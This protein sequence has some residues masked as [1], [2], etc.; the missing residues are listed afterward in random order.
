MAHDRL[1]LFQGRRVGSSIPIFLLFGLG[2]LAFFQPTHIPMAA[3]GVG[4]Q[5]QLNPADI[6]W[7]LTASGLV[8]L[9]TPGLAF[10]YGGMVGKKNI[11]SI[12]LQSFVCLGLLSLLWVVVG[13][14]LAFGD[15]Y[16]SLIG[17]PRTYFMFTNVG[18]MAQPSLAAGIPLLLFAMFQLKFAVITPALIT[19]SFAERIRFSSY[20]IFFCFFTL[21]VYCPLAHW[22]WHPQ[23]FLRQ[24]GVLGFAGGTVV[25]ISAGLAAFAGALFLGPRLSQADSKRSYLLA[26]IPYVVLGTGML[27]FGWFGF[28]RS[29]AFRTNEFTALLRLRW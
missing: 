26:N 4:A 19:G 14:S 18:T 27:W 6:A 12:M 24:M 28:N 11:I 9:M 22:A 21:F 15:S 20:L 2:I 25:H 13:F 29:A 1:G 7:M 23:G 8:L 10:F 17:D 5:A 16:H 3:E